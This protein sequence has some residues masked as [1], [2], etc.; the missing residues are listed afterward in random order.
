MIGCEIDSFDIK[1]RQLIF[2]YLFTCTH[3]FCFVL[4]F[5]FVSEGAGKSSITM[6][7][8]RILEAASGSIFIDGL[9]I[10]KLGLHDLRSKLTIIPQV[11][12]YAIGTDLKWSP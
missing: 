2:I 12:T 11:H 4:F 10:R 5:Y 7:V 9:D 8:F 6:A 1:L 3:L